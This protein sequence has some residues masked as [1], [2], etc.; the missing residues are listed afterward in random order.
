MSLKLTPILFPVLVFLVQLVYALKESLV[1]VSFVYGIFLFFYVSAS[2]GFFIFSK[3]VAKRYCPS[4]CGISFLRCYILAKLFVLIYF[5]LIGA[6]YI[7]S[8]GYEG[9]R[10]FMTSESIK[11]SAFYNRWIMYLDAYI[12][13]PLSY[14]MLVYAWASNRKTFF[15]LLAVIVVQQVFIYAS[16]MPLYNLVFLYLA[17][18]FYKTQRPLRVFYRVGPIAILLLFLS[19]LM[20]S[21]RD[22]SFH[23]VATDDIV[24]VSLFGVYLYHV[25]SPVFLD[26][27]IDQSVY[28]W[29]ISG[30]GVATFGFLVDPVLFL[31]PIDDPKAYM[32]DKLL[33]GE[34]QN[35]ILKY[36]GHVFNSF[37]TLLYPSLFDFGYFGPAIYGLFFGSVI[38]VSLKK[39]NERN[40][41]VYVVTAYFIYFGAFTFSIIGEWFWVLILSK[42][43]Y[44]ESEV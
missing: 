24:S 11:T 23:G 31:L 41:L 34:V 28:F 39:I 43:L 44:R 38:G 37:T 15:I 13:S 33:N 1:N 26:Y 32:W 9:I 4:A 22:A 36:N 7:N 40:L 10:G 6:G 12:F 29:Q 27:M 8:S 19:I 2:I 5:L 25:I 14:I 42:F 21:S 30:L 35:S 16:R 18:N 3:G 20:H 17:Y